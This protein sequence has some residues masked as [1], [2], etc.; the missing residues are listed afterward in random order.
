MVRDGLLIFNSIHKVMSAEGALKREGLDVR[1]MPVP[2]SLSSDCGLSL[3]FV[4]D[5]REE[6]ERVLDESGH[7]AEQTYR[8][9]GDV[10]LLVELFGQLDQFRRDGVGRGGWGG[11]GGRGGRG[12]GG[13][14]SRSFFAIPVDRL[15]GARLRLACCGSFLLLS[16]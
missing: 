2:R 7:P 11:W 6:V 1:V 15:C 10:Y 14:R 4:L 8:V 3:T 13:W 12:S 5:E 16:L 9:E